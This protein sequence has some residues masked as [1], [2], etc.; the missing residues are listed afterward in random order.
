[1]PGGFRR[2]ASGIPAI[3]VRFSRSCGTVQQDPVKRQETQIVQS[4]IT[5]DDFLRAPW[6]GAL[7]LRVQIP[8]GNCRSSR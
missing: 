7:S 4:C 2:R 8:P 3:Q 6:K 5:L 1:M